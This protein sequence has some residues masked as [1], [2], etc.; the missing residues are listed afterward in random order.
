[1]ATQYHSPEQI[2]KDSILW[3]YARIEHSA[4]MLLCRVLTYKLDKPLRTEI[5]FLASDNSCI[6][7]ETACLYSTLAEEI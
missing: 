3:Y 2:E 6:W 5:V 7:V 1:M 4:V